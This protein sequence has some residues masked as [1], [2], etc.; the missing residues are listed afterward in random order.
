MTDAQYREECPICGG[1]S[2]GKGPGGRLA[3]SGRNPR[4]ESCHSLER[5]RAI[6]SF[7]LSLPR[8]ALAPLKVLQFSRD[9]CVEPAWFSEFEVSVYGSSNSLNLQKIDRPTRAYDLVLC[10]HVLDHVAYDNSALHELIRVQANSGGC[11]LTVPDPIRRPSTVDWGYP[12]ETKHGHYREYGADIEELFARHLDGAYIY[13]TSLSDP[14]TLTPDVAFLLLR[15]PIES[16]A[17]FSDIS[18]QRI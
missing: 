11:F 14:V 2:F 7:F 17:V 6:R 4:C 5:H 13:K 10:N 16:N 15:A 18:A 1:T 3:V 12:D 9:R 8:Q